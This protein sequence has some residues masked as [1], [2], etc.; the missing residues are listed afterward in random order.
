MSSNV[1]FGGYPARAERPLIDPLQLPEPSAPG[2]LEPTEQKNSC[3]LPSS[4]ADA[5]DVPTALKALDFASVW[6]I[7]RGAGQ[8]VAVI[9]T[10]VTAHPR[11]PGLIAGGDYVSAGDGLFDCDAHG[12]M[13]A[14]LIAAQTAPGSGFAGGA[15]DAR[16]LSIRQSSSVFQI[17]DNRPE[18]E[19]TAEPENAAGYGNV[20]TMA[21]AIRT[22]VDS[23]ASVINI[24]EVACV[25]AG[26]GVADGPLGAAVQYA[27][28]ERNVVVVAAAGNLGSA[29]CQ[30]QNPMADPL[31]PDADPWSS[32]A[33]IATPA[34]FDDVLTVGSVESDGTPSPFSLAGPWVDVAAPGADMTSLSPTGNG[35]ANGTRGTDGV[36]PMTGTSFAAPL[37]AAVAALVRSHRPE[38]SALEVV[39]RIERTAHEPAEGWNPFVGHGIVDPLAAVTDSVTPI[40]RSV[41]ADSIAMSAPL[42]PPTPDHRP[43]TAAV[44]GSVLVAVILALGLALSVPLRRRGRT[45]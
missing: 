31:R 29:A 39:D 9:D 11:L 38:L 4:T 42:P 10:G 7:T 15:P 13:V 20:R 43:R 25:P 30:A 6:P 21:M 44:T 17:V 22:A 41:P 27:V 8:V 5:Q 33:T 36:I 1:V 19:K 16:I 40:P 26:G 14:G 45:D 37:V 2:P 35:L 28:R 24:S 34:W 12:T 18:E 32:I 23:G 3:A